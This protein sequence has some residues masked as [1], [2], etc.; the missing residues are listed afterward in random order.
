MQR[1]L[2]LIYQDILEFH[3]RALIVFKRRCE[4]RP[5][6]SSTGLLTVLVAWKKLFHSTWKT[7]NTHFNRLLENLHRHK[8]NIESEASLIEIERSQIQR[9]AQE[10]QFLV[11]ETSERER[12]ATTVLA[13]IC[14]ANVD[15]DQENLSKNWTK[16]PQFGLW[17]LNNAK[18]SAWLDSK[19]CD[20]DTLWLRGIPGAGRN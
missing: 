7:F 8:L 10:K 12:Q 9:E 11:A 3:R 17:V 4:L 14:P 2:G 13:K 18:M 20:A 19:D 1:A 16:E 5:V 15:L 6:Y